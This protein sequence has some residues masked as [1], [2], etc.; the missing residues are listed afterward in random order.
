MLTQRKFRPDESAL[1]NSSGK[2]I[3][4]NKG[5]KER[6]IYYPSHL[7]SIIYSYY[8]DILTQAYEKYLS[9][10]DYASVAVAYRKIPK[11]DLLEVTN[12]ILSLRLMRFYLLEIIGIAGYQ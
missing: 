7:D 4:T 12:V 2:R 1:K 3:R 11:N 10:K 9:D 8:N 6:H 5:K